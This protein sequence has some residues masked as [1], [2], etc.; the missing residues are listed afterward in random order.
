MQLIYILMM[1][2]SSAQMPGVQVNN[3]IM[4]GE[5]QGRFGQPDIILQGGFNNN[6]LTITSYPYISN[7]IIDSIGRERWHTPRRRRNN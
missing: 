7:V 3:N 5:Q 2:I 4:I 1:M 6:R